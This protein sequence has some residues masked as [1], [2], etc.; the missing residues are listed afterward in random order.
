MINKL[1]VDRKINPEQIKTSAQIPF[2]R[3]ANLFWVLFG[4]LLFMP[5]ELGVNGLFLAHFQI[6]LLF[7]FS[8]KI[9]KIKIIVYLGYC[10]LV[11]I[12]TMIGDDIRLTSLINPIAI[13]LALIINIKDKNQ[14]R[15]IKNGLYISAA[16]NTFFLIYLFIIQQNIGSLYFLLTARTWA[17]E[18]MPYFGNGL[19]ML[20]SLV[21]LFAFK[22]GRLKLVLLFF[23]GGVLTT[24]RVALLAMVIISIFYIIRSVK[25]IKAIAIVGLLSLSFFAPILYSTLVPDNELGGITSRLA[26]VNDRLDVY[27]LA[28]SKVYENPILGVGSEKL[29]YFG[30]AHNSYLQIAYKYGGLALI[31]W[32]MLIYLA[33]FKRLRFV[34]NIPFLLIFAIIS[35]GQIGLHNLNVLRVLAVY[36][37][38]FSENNAVKFKKLS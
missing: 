36:C 23:I 32:L 29:E 7:I 10:S 18:A 27:T 22:E 12:S 35:F 14:S 4:I 19:A 5:I 16:A 3:I 38:V 6:I 30:H 20:F 1:I 15:M 13:G 9:S 21:M 25:N 37:C 8:K 26:M 17:L 2:Q 11:L 34:K 28:L 24:S 31:F 33:Y